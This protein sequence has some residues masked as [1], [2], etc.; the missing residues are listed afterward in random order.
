MTT[1][2]QEAACETIR[3]LLSRAIDFDAHDRR[4][5]LGSSEAGATLVPEV[6][7]IASPWK[8]PHDVFLAKRG[9]ALDEAEGA[10]IDRGTFGES[11]ILQEFAR[12]H[13]DVR[14]FPTSKSTFLG[15]RE[16][17]RSASPDMLCAWPS[18]TISIV[19][20]KWPS[21]FTLKQWGDPESSE[22]QG[23]EHYRLQALWQ[24]DVLEIASFVDFAIPWNIDRWEFRFY[25]L[26][27]QRDDAERLRRAAA[28]FWRASVIG[29]IEP[30]WDGSEG[31][32]RHL[33]ILA[34]WQ[35]S[36]DR[37]KI[38]CTKDERLEALAVEHRRLKL[39]IDALDLRRKKVGQEI[40]ALLGPAYGA[41][42]GG[43]ARS[44]TWGDREKK[45][46]DHKAILE[47]ACIPEE[48]IARHTRTSRYRVLTVNLARDADGI[49]KEEESRRTEA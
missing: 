33:E 18:G 46:I 8:S 47:E 20:A 40:K 45:T 44:V 22:F 13:P 34:P 36:R 15:S 1:K 21:S 31:G 9:M 38:D 6:G 3:A 37:E 48:M 41:K 49:I 19:E 17:W 43:L 29:G 2:E 7:P 14:C 27:F 12:Q 23:P 28:R 42:L 30:E 4:T 25:R 35:E 16:P 11:L 5:T 32:D 39:R 24:M 26:P 10:H